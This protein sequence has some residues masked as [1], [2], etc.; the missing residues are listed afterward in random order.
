MR[1]K[2]CSHPGKLLEDHLINT[3]DIASSMAEHYGLAFSAKEQAALLLHDL[4]K[5]HPLSKR[6]CRACPL[7]GAALRFA[8]DPVRP[9]YIGHTLPPPWPWHLLEMYS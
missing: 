6:L 3:R 8:V 1:G 9:V 5:Y 7:A 2:P 4:G